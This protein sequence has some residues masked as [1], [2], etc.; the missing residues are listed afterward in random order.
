MI[1]E[2]PRALHPFL[3]FATALR[4]NGFAV[5]PEQTESFVEAIGLL[6][7]RGL[8]DIHRAGLAL[9][10]P[11]P[12]RRDEYDALFRMVFLGQT[13]AASAAEGDEDEVQAFDS[14]DGA[15]EPPQADE[16]RESG[17]EATG[18]EKL[19]YRAFA[20]QEA[21]A[22]LARFRRAAPSRLPRLSSRRR[23]SARTGR[24]PDLRRALRDAVRRDGEVVRL[25]MLARRS[26][27][28]RILLLID[29][30]GSMKAGTQAHLR[31]A[32]TLARVADR[33]EAFTIGTRLTRV[34]R[35]LRLR[36]GDQ[37]LALAGSL[38]ADWDG[39]TRLGD[40]LGAFLAV[41]R[42]AG[43]ARGALVLVVS[44]GLERGD[45]S[46]LVEAVGRLSRLAWSILWLTP[47]AAD[48]SFRPQTEA[49]AAIAPMVRRIGSASDTSTLC[50]EVLDFA[51]RPMP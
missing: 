42:F 44:D 5:A 1:A 21:S 12:E 9:F 27:Q 48:A 30:S 47:L 26:R 29:V 4:A 3:A 41:P 2:L 49:L 31:F 35:A 11:P 51:R 45:P 36:N 23:M 16:V 46:A 34:S 40:A 13:L 38:V 33:V 39:G 24:T 43:F 22:A 18:T 15:M 25:P 19:G 14:R 50:A 32:H 10:G 7:P 17:A 8:Q 6:G 28:R 37:A 20:P